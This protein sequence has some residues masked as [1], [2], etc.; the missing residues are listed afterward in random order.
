MRG[1]YAEWRKVLLERFGSR[2]DITKEGV[3]FHYFKP[4][5]LPNECVIEC[6]AL[7]ESE[8]GISAGLLRPDDPLAKLVEPVKTRKP[9]LWLFYR[10]REEDIQSEVN[11][12]LAKR[13]RQH[14]TEHSWP[15]LDTVGDLVRAW[16]GQR[17]D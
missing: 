1:N 15:R 9:W 7:V 10:S 5:G 14:G 11:Y 3:Y 17:P 12:Q 8:Y 13:L 2:E 4:L 6:L 16:C